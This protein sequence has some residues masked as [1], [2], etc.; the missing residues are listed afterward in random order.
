MVASY[1]PG[2]GRVKFTAQDWAVLHRF[3]QVVEGFG[4]ILGSNCEIVLHALEDPSRSVIKIANGTV[5]GRT[6][7]SPMTDFGMQILQNA[8]KLESDVVGVYHTKSNRGTPLKSATVL[9]RNPR[10][11]PIGML[12]INMDLAVPLVDF[13]REL[14]GTVQPTEERAVEHF[15]ISA[16]E[17]VASTLEEALV[18][19]NSGRR[20]STRERNRLVVAQL[21]NRGVFRVKGAVDIIARKMG[22]SR[23]TVYNYLREARVDSAQGTWPG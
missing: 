10:G 9:I 19:A 15:P 21:H 12:C 14:V 7:G 17:L 16:T 22:V 20:L 18:E 6:I 23:Y 8:D 13:A 2:D 11:K 1:R 3:E 5:T 4:Q